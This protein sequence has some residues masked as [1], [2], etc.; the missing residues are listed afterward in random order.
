MTTT[1]LTMTM[2]TSSIMHMCTVSIDRYAGIRDP[3]KVKFHQPFA[4]FVALIATAC[5]DVMIVEAL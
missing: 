1:T 2:C 3:I 5:H 4:M